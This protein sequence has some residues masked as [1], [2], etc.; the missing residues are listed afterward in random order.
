MTLCALL[1]P[2]GEALALGLGR[3]ERDRRIA[4]GEGHGVL[5]PA[6]IGRTWLGHLHTGS[7][8]RHLF[9]VDAPY[10]AQI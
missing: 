5:A 2:A 10:M 3:I 1:E 6:K 7:F 9:I 4:A 8:D